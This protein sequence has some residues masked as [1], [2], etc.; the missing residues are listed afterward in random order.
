MVWE[1]I[2]VWIVCWSTVWF[3]RSVFPCCWD[4]AHGFSDRRYL[5][6]IREKGCDREWHGDSCHYNSA[7][8]LCGIMDLFPGALRGMGHSAVPM[9]LSVIGT[10]GTRILWIF[11]FSHITNRCTS[12]LFLIRHPGSS[13][14]WCRSSVFI[15]WEKRCA[16]NWC[17]DK[18][19]RK[20]V[21]KIGND[22]GHLVSWRKKKNML[23][24]WKLKQ[25]K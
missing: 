7:V 21:P 4:V 25:R 8:F 5:V 14:L 24:W 12:C 2:N 11:G 16:G 6:Y 3:L 18:T 20:N 22:F 23:P 1:N 17:G 10:V 13:R 15:L 9:I 19:Q